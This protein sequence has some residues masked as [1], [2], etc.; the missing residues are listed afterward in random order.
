MYIKL[1][2]KLY[3]F[4]EYWFK[5]LFKIFQKYYFKNK[6][7]YLKILRKNI[8]IFHY[9][10]FLEIYKNSEIK[11]FNYIESFNIIYIFKIF[12][13]NNIKHFIFILLK[14]N[15]IIFYIL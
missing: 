1:F 13:K 11:K 9:N 10:F 14:I 12:N 4:I 2:F 3:N 7:I 6:S 8:C 15:L 5:I